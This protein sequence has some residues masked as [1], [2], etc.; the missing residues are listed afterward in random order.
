[1]LVFKETS[2]DKTSAQSSRDFFKEIFMKKWVDD[3]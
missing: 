2:Y 1:M 3:Y